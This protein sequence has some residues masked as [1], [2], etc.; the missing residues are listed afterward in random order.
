MRKGSSLNVM[1]GSR[2]V[3]IIPF[4]RSFM[5]S[6]GSTSMPQCS[7]FRQRAKA[8]MVKSLRFW[9]SCRLPSSTIGLRESWLYD[10]FRAP[11]NSI[12]IFSFW[13]L[14]FTCAVPKFRNVD[15]W[16]RF[17]SL[18]VTASASSIPLPKVTMSMSLENITY[19]SS[20]DETR[21][22]H[23]I[24]NFTD[25][26]KYRVVQMVEYKIVVGLHGYW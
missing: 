18:V 4:F 5:P 24:G 6:N 23:L 20:D 17:P 22:I 13:S 9:S 10:S 14:Y 3:R 25:E 21:A 11:T 15:R 7:L 16:A 1:S 26:M 19:I 12:S 8:L 2:G